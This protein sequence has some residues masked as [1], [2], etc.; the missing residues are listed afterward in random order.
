M[1]QQSF[2]TLDISTKTV[3]IKRKD[4]VYKAIAHPG[5]PS[6]TTLH[7][8]S[9]EGFSSFT[10]TFKQY[11]GSANKFTVEGSNDGIIWVPIKMRLQ[12]NRPS[13][14]ANLFIPANDVTQIFVTNKTTRFARVKIA[15]TSPSSRTDLL[16]SVSGDSITFD[17]SSIENNVDYN[18]TYVAPTGG[19]SATTSIKAAVAPAYR[20]AIKRVIVTNTSA[21]ASE[22]TIT[23]STAVVLWRDTVP[24][25]GRIDVSFPF[26]LVATPTASLNF[27]VTGTPTLFVNVYGVQINAN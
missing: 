7:Q 22:I 9:M 4:V 21:T 19:I 11:D 10:I 24:A 26:L 14:M 1:A 20:S 8:W 12:G 6:N 2:P 3:T 5:I 27:T 18:W 25:N 23:D 13:F 16:V 15:T 17:D